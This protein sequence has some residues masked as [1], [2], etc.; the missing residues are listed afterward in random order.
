[1]IQ[2]FLVLM[3]SFLGLASQAR[4]FKILSQ[5]YMPVCGFRPDGKMAGIQ[6]EVAKE[7]EKIT[8][9]GTENRLFIYPEQN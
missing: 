5:E 8:K 9:L 2:F 3:T 4:D 1:M 7:L 6:Y